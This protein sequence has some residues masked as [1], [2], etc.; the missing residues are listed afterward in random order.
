MSVPRDHP[1]YVAPNV[2]L[3]VIR[4]ILTVLQVGCIIAAN[5]DSYTK[6]L[7]SLEKPSQVSTSVQGAGPTFTLMRQ[8]F[9]LGSAT[10]LYDI[11]TLFFCSQEQA[12][13][14]LIFFCG[15][16]YLF[17]VRPI[18]WIVRFL[19]PLSTSITSIQVG[20][21]YTLILLCKQILQRLILM[22]IKSVETKLVCE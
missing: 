12:F 7:A 16:T 17:Q 11:T 1:D 15:M 22:C 10:Y 9:L 18:M 6:Y 5:V 13:I 21:A 14:R 20:I 2:L 19:C 8:I 3:L 4:F